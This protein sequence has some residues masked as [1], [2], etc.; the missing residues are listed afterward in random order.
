MAGAFHSPLM[1]DAVQPVREAISRIQFREPAFPIIPNSSGKPTSQPLILRDLLARHL[2]SPVRWDATM[3][4]MADMG[5][6]A[7]IEAGPGDV[8][9]KL[10]RR[11]IPTALV[12]SVGTPDEARAVVE[13]LR[14]HAAVAKTEEAR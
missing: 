12:R 13:D 1:A 7:I 10:A 3:Q 9:G 14:K 4:S 2:I 8:L 11:A 5:I 6:N